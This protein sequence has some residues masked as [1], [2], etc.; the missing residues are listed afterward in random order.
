MR[1]NTSLLRIK[2]MPQLRAPPEAA[3]PQLRGIEK[4]LEKNPE[5]VLLT[6][7]RLLNW[8]RSVTHSS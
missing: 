6:R 2:D 8:S 4:R 7:R 5:L 3:L 1:V